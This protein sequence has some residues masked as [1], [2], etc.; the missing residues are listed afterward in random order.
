MPASSFTRAL[1]LGLAGV[2]LMAGGFILGRRQSTPDVKPQPSPSTRAALGSAIPSPVPPAGARPA[3]VAA[4]SMPVAQPG[5]PVDA[6]A[7]PHT[8]SAPR[9]A[10]PAPRRAPTA[11]APSPAPA[12][13]EPAVPLEP[14]AVPGQRAFVAGLTQIASTRSARADLKGFDPTAVALK[15][16]PESE[17]AIE[18][19]VAPTR[20]QPGQPYVVKVYLR[21]RGSRSIRVKSL[22]VASEMNGRSSRTALS[23]HSKT[24]DP[25]LVGLLAELPGVWKDDVS[26]W[27]IAVDVATASGDTYS[28]RVAWK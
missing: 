28:S 3:P 21:N 10:R 15:R 1:L 9:A 5:R 11:A 13:A 23:P 7:P 17:G 22:S 14:A 8:A 18:F 19:E 2:A 16:A 6:P 26:S 27:S 25:S 12:P 20:V 4:E 24:V